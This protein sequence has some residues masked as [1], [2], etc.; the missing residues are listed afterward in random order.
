MA[1]Y[2]KTFLPVFTEFVC[3]LLFIYIGC[4]S[5]VS[6]K[7]TEKADNDLLSAIDTARMIAIAMAHGFVIAALVFA[8]APISGG[9]LNPVVTLGMILTGNISIRKG[10]A[11]IIAQFSGG[12]AGAGLL[13]VSFNATLR[14]NLGS[15]DIGNGV[16][17]FGGIVIEFMLTF[18]LLF[19]IFS[20]AVYKKGNVQLAPLAIG[21]V[22]FVDH[23]VGLPF[24]GASMNPARTL[25]P[26]VVTQHFDHIYIYFIGP[27]LGAAAA[28]LLYH[29]LYLRKYRDELEYVTVQ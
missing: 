1:N 8:S 18:V 12:I 20:T 10:V 17:V 6:S 27:P 22:V 24:T 4:G 15:H 23:L 21:L 11:Y 16:D 26:A 13:A 28:S 19:V 29:F 14:G 7:I 9:M 25:A 2:Q 5:V 3:T